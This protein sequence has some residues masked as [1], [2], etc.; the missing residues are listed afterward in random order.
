MFLNNLG[1]GRDS[2]AI[3]Y[4]PGSQTTC[5]CTALPADGGNPISECT[6]VDICLCVQEPQEVV[7]ATYHRKVRRG[8]ILVNTIK[9]DVAY[10]IPI[11]KSIQQLLHDDAILEEVMFNQDVV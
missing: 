2:T 5:K 9:R 8:N 4:I 6:L 10:Y 7:I 1:I 3:Q 11:L